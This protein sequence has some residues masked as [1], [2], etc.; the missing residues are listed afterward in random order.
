MGI[1]WL[2]VL[3]F[4]FMIGLFFLIL[5]IGFWIGDRRK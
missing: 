1:H 5:H 4:L 3:I 2:D